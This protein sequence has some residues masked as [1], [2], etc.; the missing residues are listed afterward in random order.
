VASAPAH[1]THSVSGMHRG[2]GERETADL[3]WKP[4]N[5]IAG[6]W[7]PP[8]AGHGGELR[9][10]APPY[11][12]WGPWPAAGA[13]EL[14][15][16]LAALEPAARAWAARPERD[17][18]A[19]LRRAIEGVGD[20]APGAALPAFLG[21]AREE[22]AHH[23]EGW[24]PRLSRHLEDPAAAG[25]P[26]GGIEVVAPHWT[27]LLGRL[28]ET[29]VGAL[30]RGR[31]V[32]L[33]SD[34][35]LPL[36]AEA[37]ARALDAAGLEPG[38]LALLHGLAEGGVLQAAAHPSVRA[39][40]ASGTAAELEPL[41][42]PDGPEH[43]PERTLE[44]LDPGGG[45][46]QWVPS[47]ADP[48]Q[49]ADW[50][51][52]EAFDRARTLSGQLPGRV[53]RVLCHDRQVSAFTE[54]LLDA[55]AESDSIGRPVPLADA[56]A[57]ERT[58]ALWELGL[59]EGATL[60]AG[61]ERYPEDARGARRAADRRVAPT[62]F[63]NVEPHMQVVRGAALSPVLSLLRVPSDAAGADLLARMG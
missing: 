49:A 38:A 7:R 2:R 63:T 57:L 10:G 35:R 37:W 21:L 29:L 58:E 46:S 14:A 3:A 32:L 18:R 33:V 43:A 36:A 28:G 40:R 27:D 45:R 48:R 13:A 1:S 6:S 54:A 4:G 39:L 31:G 42:A 30:A 24:V 56:R 17:R 16:A 55:L 12:S 9:S 22:F 19:C 50:V 5:W 23:R 41:E 59:D 60:I 47:T 34:P 53:S 15:E 62:V 26:A 8:G 25:G 52:Q 11:A 44:L 20:T 51:A 61:G